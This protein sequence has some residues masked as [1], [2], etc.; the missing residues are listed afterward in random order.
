MFE[1]DWHA[2][3]ADYDRPDSK[4]YRR[5]TAVKAQIGAA[6]DEA[7]PG[8][9]RAVSLCAGQGRDLI[10]VLARH[11]RGADVSAKLVELDPR[12][13]AAANESAS[14]AGLTGVRA[15]IGDAASTSN[16]LD[17]APADLVLV[18]GVFGN[19]R[20]AD[21]DRLIGHCTQLC[22]TGGTV[23]WTRHREVPDVVPQIC[24]WFAERG[25]EQLWVSDPAAGHGVGRH[26]Y[27]KDPAPLQPDTSMFTFVGHDRLAPGGP[28]WL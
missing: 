23:V 15:V 11:P 28:W 14:R 27:L 12:N 25:F 6:L 24:D 3:H 9:L 20:H 22:R 26:R 4:L 8:P 5:L 1:R 13:V 17:M 7:P 16:Y 10:E 2:W 21:V 19:L 18:C